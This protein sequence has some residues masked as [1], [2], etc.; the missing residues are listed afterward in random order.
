ME[1]LLPKLRI[2]KTKSRV[3]DVERLVDEYS[4]VGKGL[5]KKETNIQI[6]LNLK[7]RL[8][9]GEIGVIEGSFGQSGKFKI[10]IPAGLSLETINLIN[11]VQKKKGKGKASAVADGE[12]REK[13]ASPVK[14]ILDF[15]RYIFD[16]DKR[17]IQT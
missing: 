17:M 6:F 14:I 16:P 10:R 2:F 3:G 13:P 9:T 8:S 5:F 4:L 1:A 15:K 7:V 12:D 11:A